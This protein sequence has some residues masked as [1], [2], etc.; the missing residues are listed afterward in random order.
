ML[1]QQPERGN[2]TR[3]ELAIEKKDEILWFHHWNETFSG[4]FFHWLIHFNVFTKWSLWFGGLERFSYIIFIR[5]NMMFTMTHLN[6]CTGIRTRCNNTQSFHI[7]YCLIIC[8]IR[9]SFTMWEL[10][11]L[12]MQLEEMVQ[13]NGNYWVRN[14]CISGEKKNSAAWD[15][16]ALYLVEFITHC[17]W[18]FIPVWDESIEPCSQY[19]SSCPGEIK[20]IRDK[21][22]S[23]I[24]QTVGKKRREEKRRGIG[25]EKG[26]NCRN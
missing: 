14:T 9:I 17:G 19:A 22:N 20:E 18:N 1:N 15:W 8:V 12:L 4:V 26:Y 21:I 11:L 24:R 23:T 3:L 25:F 6:T 13:K 10:E 5:V 2:K 7:N 16:G